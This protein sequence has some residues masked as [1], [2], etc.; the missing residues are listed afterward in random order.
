ML[1]NMSI[2][3]FMH[4]CMRIRVDLCM[5]MNMDVYLCRYVCAYNEF[6]LYDYVEFCEDTVG[7][8]LRHIN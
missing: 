4:M 8:K 3:V 1:V 6:V 2:S 7:V 5:Y